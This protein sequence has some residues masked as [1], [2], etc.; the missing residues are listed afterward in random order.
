[1]TETDTRYFREVLGHFATGVVVVTGIWR[2]VPVGFSAQSFVSLSLDPPLV[3]VCPARTS[4]TWPRLRETGRFCVN[5]LRDD[6]RALCQTFARSGIDRYEGVDWRP[7]V[8]GSPVLA[9]ALAWVDCELEA[10]H[11]GGDHVIAVGRVRD[12]G[13]RDGSRGPLL[14]FRGGYGGFASADG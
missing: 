11:E 14:F 3:A 4:S 7:G 2:D 6:Q 8:T 13:V 5:V 9:Q 10:E 12:L 1:M